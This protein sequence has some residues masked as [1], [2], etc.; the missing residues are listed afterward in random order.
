MDLKGKQALLV[1]L[2]KTGVSTLKVLANLGV[3]VT[4]S[5]S[6]TSDDLKEVIDEIN[7]IGKFEY[8]L[9]TSEIQTDKFDFMV[10]SPG[11]PLTIGFIKD[12]KEKGK[13]VYSDIE[14][15]SLL[16]NKTRH[17]SIT[18]TNGKTTTTALTGEIFKAANKETY[19][20]GNIGNPIM[21][22]IC[23]ASQDSYMVT[24]LSSFQLESV[25]RYKPYACAILNISPD[26]L[27]RHKTME[28]YM[29]AKYRIFKSQSDKDYCILNYDDQ[30]L[31][32]LNP[33]VRGK[34]LWFSRKSKVQGMYV[35]DGFIIVNLPS[36]E[37]Y[38][39]IAT[40]E[41][42]L[43]GGHNLENIMAASL[44]A[45]VSGIDKESIVSVLKTFKAVEHRL[46]FVDEVDGVKYYNDS[47][48]TNPDSTIKAVTSYTDPIILIAGG[49]DKKSDYNELMSIAKD[50]VK[51]VITLG[52]TAK[53]VEKAAKSNGINRVYQAKDM[54]EVVNLAHELA[55]KGD[56]VLLSP[57]SASWG[58]YNNYEERGRDFKNRVKMLKSRSE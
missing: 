47:K 32:K 20:V 49:Y 58:M 38:K 46:E 21:D 26:H 39:L 34:L 24:E 43:P 28:N 13:A 1:G 29:E 30:E 37:P 17:I 4:L 14:L 27:N 9:G 40:N 12:F 52:Q 51:I 23:E 8:I 55:K 19:I 7:K 15:A 54:E 16:N 2:A 10:V 22:V 53:E 18:G 31:K 48:G 44:L 25:D 56:I 41:L 35:E 5:D 6:K 42:T 50:T 45:L 33:R 3:K 57:A 11:V 36:Q